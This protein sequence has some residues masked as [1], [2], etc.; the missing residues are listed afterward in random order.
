MKY[1]FEKYPFSPILG[2]SISRYEL[3]NKCRRQYYYMY[4][5]KY[6]KAVPVYKINQLKEM[7]SVPLEIGNVIHDVL[8]AFLR[9]LQKSDERIDETRFFEYAEKCTRQYFSEKQFIEL[10]YGYND[11]LSMEYVL[12]KI[13]LCLDNFITSSCFNWIFMAALHDKENWIIEPEGYGETRLNGC[14]VYCKMDFLLPVDGCIHIL[15]W[16]TGKRDEQK[17]TLQLIGYAAAAAALFKVEWKNI[18]PR[19]VYLSPEFDEFSIT[20]GDAERDRFY[21][22]IAAQTNEMYDLCS[23]VENNIPK[24]IEAFPMQPSPTLCKQCKFRE[25][26]FPDFRL[27]TPSTE[28]ELF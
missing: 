26:C 19:I 16:K 12:D 11:A 1:S 2:W 7:T 3:F 23:N 13:K 25:L 22:L 20:V 24:D 27:V 9:R 5:G 21:E 4:Y 28:T 17:H 15:D 8:E 6:C 14:K 18:L 10:Y